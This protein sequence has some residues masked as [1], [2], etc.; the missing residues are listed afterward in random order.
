M[1]SITAEDEEFEET[2]VALKKA[3]TETGSVID[4][5]VTLQWGPKDLEDLTSQLE[6]VRS[7]L[8]YGSDDS[9]WIPGTTLGQAVE[10][11]AAI[12]YDLQQ[13]ILLAPCEVSR[14][15]ELTYECRADRLC[16]VCT[17]RSEVFR[18]LR[19]DHGMM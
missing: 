19:E 5:R 17:W 8:R 7:A 15:G 4:P 2:L 16:R 10:R 3:G 11:L 14:I 18:A 12:V 9:I 1:F 13:S 6:A